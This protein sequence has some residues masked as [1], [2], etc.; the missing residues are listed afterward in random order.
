MHVEERPERKEELRAA[1]LLTG[2]IVLA[3]ALRFWRLGEWN[4]QAT[5]IFTL[6]DSSSPQFGNPRPL[7]YLLNYYV[8]RPLLPLNE[9]GLRLLP[10]LFGVLTIPA[11]YFIARSLVGVRA[12]LFGTLLLVFS[13]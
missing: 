5:E 8:V 1:L 13:P 3:A 7:G 6:R 4:F 10:A 2:L 12:A 11:F 9:F